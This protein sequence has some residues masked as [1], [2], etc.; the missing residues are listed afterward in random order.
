MFY[1]P[2]LRRNLLS[3]GLLT[4][5]GI[6][7]ILM[8]NKAELVHNGIKVAEGIKLSNNV[9]RL[10]LKTVPCCEANTA[11]CDLNLKML[12]ERLGHVNVGTIE[13]MI[14]H[15]LLPSID[16]KDIKSFFCEPCQIGKMHR[17]SY[18]LIK[19]GRDAKR[20]YTQ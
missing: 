13:R 5:K 9:Y 18:K 4:G 8:E 6:R 10:A 16:L 17:K 1:V 2:T 7:V 20:S 15:K 3:V 11:E 14:K 12:H 19:D